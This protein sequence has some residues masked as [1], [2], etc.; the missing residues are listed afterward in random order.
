MSTASG[1][2]PPA[3]SARAPEDIWARR[4]AI[5]VALLGLVVVVVPAA[6]HIGQVLGDDPFV[7]RKRTVTVVREVDGKTDTETT[8]SP[9]DTAVLDRALSSGGLLLLRLGVVAI[10]AFLAGATVQRVIAGDFSGKF[11][12]LELR[13]VS[14]AAA[15][16]STTVKELAQGVEDQ[17]AVTRQAVALASQTARRL[18]ALED[19]L[20]DAQ[21]S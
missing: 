19:R 2:Q 18:K 12:P 13:R 11:G 10:A 3:P 1:T 15:A 9:E 20:A 5:A 16:S 7:A 14:K 8:T 17:M 21:D 4:A 6:L